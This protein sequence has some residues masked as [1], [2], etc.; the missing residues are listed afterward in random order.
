MSILR[1]GGIASGLDTEQIIK[2]LMRIERMKTDKL[3]QQKQVMEWRKE[4]LRE[5]T[6]KIRSFRDEYFNLAKPQTNL[7][8]LASLK[9][10]IAKSTS[11]LVSVSAGADA[12]SGQTTIQILQSAT[13]AKATVQVTGIDGQQLSLSDTMEAVSEKLGDALAFDENGQLAITINDTQIIVNKTDTLSTVITRINASSAGVQAHFSSFSNTFSL[14]AKATGEGYITVNDDSNFFAALGFQVGENGEIGQAGRDAIFKINGHEGKS[15]SNAF[16]IDGITYTITSQVDEPTENITVTV[17][18]DTE[19]IY[20]VI[21][22]F[23]NDYN[24][25]IDSINRKLTEE[26]FRDF[27]P[28]TKE[29]KEEMTE[30]EIELWEEKAK[31][32]LL[33]GESAL[34]KLLLDLRK[35]L[36]D[37]VG[38]HHLAQIGIETSR[39]Y[40]DRGKLVLKDGGAVLREAIAANPDKV[41]DLFARRPDIDY[42]PNLTAEQRKERYENAGLA[43]RISDILSDNIRTTRDSQGRKGILLELAGIEGDLSEF[44]NFID[45]QIREINERLDRLNEQLNRKEEQYYRQFTAMEKALQQLY[46]QGDWLT[47]QLTAGLFGN[48]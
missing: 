43:Y 46:S 36:Y 31:S 2:D 5:I 24:A 17:S 45:R 21:E 18:T 48:K 37:A 44:Q 23:V 6:N 42:S 35:A 3:S 8:S 47:M 38:E 4:L 13:S 7:M 39:D 40:R 33:R 20:Q 12:L 29:Q 16:T 26:R 25:L 28:L 22:K 34:E 10:N 9:K 11:S 27:L 1:I 14:T 15:K 41:A 19:A 32:G 30:K